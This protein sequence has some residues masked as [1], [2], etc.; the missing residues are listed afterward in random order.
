MNI[1]LIS[2][3]YPSEGYPNYG[4]FVKNT[5]EILKKEGWNVD[6]TVLYKGTNKIN[7]FLSYFLY[8][9]NILI[10]GLFKEYD[11]LYVHYASHNA[12]PLILLK[13]LRKNIKIFI[14]V[15]GSD[16]VPEV[17]SQEK[18]QP[19]VRQ[20]LH[21]SD[22]IIT[23]SNY[24][25]NLVTEKYGVEALK[26]NVFPSGGV[27]K[28][29]FH[30]E[31]NR[32]MVLA[33]LNLSP[34]YKYLGFVGRLDIGKGWDILLKSIKKLKDLGL[35][36]GRKLIFVGK[37]SQQKEY[38]ESV[39]K[40]NLQSDIVYYPL[41]K[42]EQLSK[43]YNCLEVFCFPTTRK[44]ESL[45]LVGLEAMA[46][47]VPVIGSRIGGLLDYIQNEENGFLFDVG[48]D[49]DLTQKL[50]HYIN[51]NELERLS[52]Q[53][54]ALMTAEMYEVEKIAPKLIEIFKKYQRSE[55]FK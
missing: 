38:E 47:G 26:I 30:K 2:N 46:C 4:I 44:G 53:K 41:L 31:E 9:L 52:M 13:K 23:P 45:G 28:K 22:I 54:A 33:D 24:Y 35:L 40:L 12:I 8:Y 21:I 18:Y 36:E 16:I 1:H 19:Y 49:D 11:V 51:L 39:S 5:E 15:H 48:S 55:S 50:I 6:K 3:M 17:S 7:K 14:N 34:E 10:K 42:Q 43:I 20:L 32:E 25:K 37:G 27:N 29:I